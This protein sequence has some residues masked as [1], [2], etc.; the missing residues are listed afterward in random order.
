MRVPTSPGI[1]P[2]Q[3]WNY[4]DPDSGVPFKENHVDA[5]Y[6]LVRR[7]RI[8][9]N[10]PVGAEW[11][12]TYWDTL[13]EQN[14]KAPCHEEGV[15]QYL[16]NF[17]DISGFVN[18]LIAQRESGKTQV[19]QAEY[20][21]R[22]AICM[23]CPALTT[24]NCSSCGSFARLLQRVIAGVVVPND[25]AHGKSCSVCGCNVASKC[26]YPVDVLRSVDAELGRNPAYIKDHCWML[27][28]PQ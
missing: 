1:V 17:D 21:R 15:K 19:D 22:T 5:L 16:P 24:V 23:S 3:G 18:T 12:A 20:E 14:P 8:A 13:C 9:N 6:G 11:T 28:E 10:L 25:V 26:A 7:H 27:E 2:P 4:K